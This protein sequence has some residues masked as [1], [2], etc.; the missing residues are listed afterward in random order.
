MSLLSQQSNLVGR[1]RIKALKRLMKRGSNGAFMK[2]A[3][4]YKNGSNGVFQSDTKAL[5]MRIR[6]A[7]LGYTKAYVAIGVDY[8]TGTLVAED[9]SKALEYYEVAAK[10]GSV[11]ATALGYMR[12]YLGCR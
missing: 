9:L 7:E 6:A 5:E 2:M 10:K 3:Y 1:H 4:H 12:V 8:Q 11:Q